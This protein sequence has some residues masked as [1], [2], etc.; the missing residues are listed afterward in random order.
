MITWA[1][2]WL[3]VVARP[4]GDVGDLLQLSILTDAF[5]VATIAIA[6]A[7]CIYKE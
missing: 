7:F 1:I 5:I 2:C 3:L 6:T 4:H